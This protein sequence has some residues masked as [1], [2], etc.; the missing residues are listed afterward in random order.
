MLLA[1][2]EGFEVV[3]YSLN[4]QLE[5]PALK[6]FIYSDPSSNFFLFAFL[7]EKCTVMREITKIHS[8]NSFYQN[9]K[10][11][12]VYYYYYYC[13]IIIIIISR[14]LVTYDCSRYYARHADILL[15][16]ADPVT[17]IF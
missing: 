6:T 10:K 3:S 12:L 2:F 16:I 1:L 4:H 13:F 17:S 9:Y 14:V 8:I 15:L 11:M 7:T 5:Y